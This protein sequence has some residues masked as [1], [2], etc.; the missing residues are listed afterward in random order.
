MSGW[1]RR[2]DNGGWE[3]QVTALTSS[4]GA[5]CGRA[6]AVERRAAGLAERARQRAESIAPPIVG[7]RERISISRIRMKASTTVRSRHTRVEAPDPRTA[8]M[9]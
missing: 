6:L 2:P 1:G 4:F 9:R 7:D 5:G 3:V 8:D